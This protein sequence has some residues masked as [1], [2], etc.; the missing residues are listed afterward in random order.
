M[1]GLPAGAN[2]VIEFQ[3]ITDHGDLA[4][5]IG[6]VADQGCAFHRGADLAI[7]DHVGLGGGKDE[8]P[9]GDI[10][11]ATTEI[12]GVNA[13]LDGGEDFLWAMLTVQHERVGHARHRHMGMGL[14]AAITGRGNPHEPGILAILHVSLED[15]IL[16]QHVAGRWRAFIIN[17]DGPAPVIH[18][19]V[20]D[21][22]HTPGGDLFTDTA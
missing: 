20:I 4:H 18:G 10:N 15:T 3:V 13:F 14:A 5:G 7:F 11:L 8:F 6:S 12:D 1:P 17:R 9:A 21:N 19:A 22:G 2:A 16:N